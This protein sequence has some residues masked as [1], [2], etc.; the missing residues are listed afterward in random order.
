[1]CHL[2]QTNSYAVLCS[3][4]PD[5]GEAT[6]CCYWGVNQSATG[7]TP[8]NA[9]DYDY[10][11]HKNGI[12]GNYWKLRHFSNPQYSNILV[13][14]TTH[15]CWSLTAKQIRHVKCHQTFFFENKHALTSF[16]GGRRS[17]A[18][19]AGVAYNVKPRSRGVARNLFWGG[20]NFYCTIYCSLIY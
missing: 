8:T 1:M 5:P 12:T 4:A 18:D 7:N 20:I 14:S 19:P 2:R 6:D 11:P 16:V 10:V 17:T 9:N 3:V 13:V 15:R